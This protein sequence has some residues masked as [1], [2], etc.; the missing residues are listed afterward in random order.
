MDRNAV[1]Q[2]GTMAPAVRASPPFLV[3]VFAM[4]AWE[5]GPT[6]STQE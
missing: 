3:G 2:S 5:N 1:V 4:G 6:A